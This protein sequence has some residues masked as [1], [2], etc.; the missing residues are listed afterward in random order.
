MVMRMV[1]GKTVGK[2]AGVTLGAT[3]VVG[4][5]LGMI[6]GVLLYKKASEFLDGRDNEPETQA[7]QTP[8]TL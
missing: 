1:S 6:T 3:L 8:D 5:A 7:P 4:V 2:V